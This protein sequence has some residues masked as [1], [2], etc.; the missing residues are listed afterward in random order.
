MGGSSAGVWGFGIKELIWERD[1]GKAS[2]RNGR[3]WLPIHF[4]LGGLEDEAVSVDPVMEAEFGGGFE[5]QGMR[6]VVEV[7]GHG[8]GVTG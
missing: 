3:G 8:F 4:Q 6:G 2:G 1:E 7:K 5:G